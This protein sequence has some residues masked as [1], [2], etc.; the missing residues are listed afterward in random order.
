MKRFVTAYRKA[1][2][3]TMQH[4]EEAASITAKAVPGYAERRT[5]C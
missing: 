3:Y 2:D 4:P 1:F 5:C